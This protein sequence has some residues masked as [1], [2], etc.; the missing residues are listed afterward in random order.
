[1]R[2]TWED[3]VEDFLEIACRMNRAERSPVL[4]NLRQEGLSAEHL[5][6]HPAFSIQGRLMVIL[7]KAPVR[8]CTVY[9][10]RSGRFETMEISSEPVY[11]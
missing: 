8:K 11:R 2:Q 10:L 1:M 7:K 5:D 3:L 6:V 4:E 9:V